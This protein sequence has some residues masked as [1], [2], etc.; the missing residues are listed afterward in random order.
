MEATNI[1]YFKEKEY[2]IIADVGMG[3]CLPSNSSKYKVKI[4]IGDFEEVITANPKEYKNGYNRWSERIQKMMKTKYFS[5]DEMDK[6]FIYL[7]DGNHP[8]CF[9][10]GRVSEFSDQDPGQRWFIL[11][12]DKA[13]GKVENDYDA[14]MLQLKLA[15]ND[16]QKNGMVDFEKMPGWKKKPPRRLGSK[17]IRC[18][19]Y[20]CRNIPSAD[21][22]GSSDSYISVW[23]PE[24]D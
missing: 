13:V 9:W 24:G 7:M 14:G 17:K 10:K 12:V 18:F 21:A 3:I 23:N 5:L 22:D 11:K 1:G 8:I 4:K 15:I 2:Q 19:I 20:Q 6:I 16:V